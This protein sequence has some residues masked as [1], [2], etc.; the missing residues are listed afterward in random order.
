MASVDSNIFFP[1][2]IYIN[3]DLILFNKMI[4]WKKKVDL[5]REKFARTYIFLKQNWKEFFKNWRA[6]KLDFWE[7][8][9]LLAIS[10]F[11]KENK[12]IQPSSP[13]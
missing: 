13:F 11:F 12:Y 9:C 8:S 10:L 7:I 3:I 6:H 5:E 1:S 4:I 2:L